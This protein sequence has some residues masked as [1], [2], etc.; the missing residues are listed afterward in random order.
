[1]KATAE[2][3]KPRKFVSNRLRAKGLNTLKQ[4]EN[5]QSS[6]QADALKIKQFQL[7][8]IYMP[9]RSAQLQN[10]WMHG[11]ISFDAVGVPNQKMAKDSYPDESFRDLARSL[12]TL[13]E[14]HKLVSLA[15]PKRRLLASKEMEAWLAFIDARKDQLKNN[16]DF[17]IDAATLVKLKDC[18]DRHRDR[19]TARV[20]SEKIID[21][22]QMFAGNF[23]FKVPIHPRNLAQIIH[24]HYGYMASFKP[25]TKFFSWNQMQQVY[26]I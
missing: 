22:H 23:R 4:F 6:S 26:Q 12:R 16:P 1:M 20:P 19:T 5:L 9:A 25:G 10:Q 8:P 3:I 7:D 21:V 13:R 18:F 11:D 15:G 24:P 17:T 14:E 2:M